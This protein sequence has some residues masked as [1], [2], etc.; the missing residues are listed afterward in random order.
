M[1]SHVWRTILILGLT[2]MPVRG[3]P[4]GA[5][6][7]HS[8]ESYRRA[9]DV[10]DAGIEALGGLERLSASPPLAIRFEG[11]LHW[12]HQ[13]RLPEPPYDAEPFTATFILDRAGER[14]LYENE[15]RLP[16][17]FR[18]HNRQVIEGEK[19]FAI[20]L[21]RRAV[22]EIDDPPAIGDHFYVERVPHLLVMRLLGNA[23]SLRWLGTVEVGG[24]P[25]EAIVAVDDG[26]Q[27]T[28]F[29]DPETRLLNAYE[30][31]LTDPIGGDV[32]QRRTW[33]GYNLVNGFRYR[34]ATFKRSRAP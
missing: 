18:G 8:L 4:P 27:V 10:L 12:R 32:V 17:G 30:R 21:I 34:R 29:F 25:H 13:S 2:A 3:Q 26:N 16:G 33:E 22:S 31:I 23:A 15:W 14:L 19:G 5:E 9:R 28:L 7:S 11:A 20:D 24:R 1:P 6:S